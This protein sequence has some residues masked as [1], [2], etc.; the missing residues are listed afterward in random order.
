MV[1]TIH[2]APHTGFYPLYETRRKEVTPLKKIVLVAVNA[3]Y[4]HSNAA[5]YSLIRYNKPMQITPLEFTANDGFHYILSEIYAS[6]P[7][8]LGFSCYIWNIHIILPLVSAVKKI[9]PDVTVILGGPEVSYDA[10]QVLEQTPADIVVL[11]EGE[12]TLRQ[13]LTDKPL[14]MIKGIIYRNENNQIITNPLR[15]KLFVS[16]IPFPYNEEN[17]PQNKII[18]YESSRGCPFSCGYCLS[19]N[20]KPVRFLPLRR[21]FA[22]LDFFI[23]HRVTQVKFTDRT[24]NC[25]KNRA[26]LIWKYLIDN[27]NGYT[28]FHFELAADLLDDEILTEL[29]NAPDG[30]FQFEIGIQS[31][32]AETL[33]AINRNMLPNRVTENIKKIKTHENIH[34][35]LDLIAGLPAESYERFKESFDTVYDLSPD[36]LQLGFLKLLKGSTLRENAIKHGIVYN[37]HPPYEVLSTHDITYGELKNLKQIEK[38]VDLLYNSGNFT[39]TLSYIRPFFPSP[40]YFYES[41][42][43]YWQTQGFHRSSQNLY[44]VY[45]IL[46]AFLEPFCD[47]DILANHLKY[48]WYNN[49]NQKNFPL[50]LCAF[51]EE[52][53]KIINDLYKSTQK[54]KRY[55][56]KKFTHPYHGYI[57]FEYIGKPRPGSQKKYVKTVKFIISP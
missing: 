42:A 2:N 24:F 41:F 47:K 53:P 22:D 7:D 32:H 5:I 44:A 12:E 51:L 37:D 17:L 6:A 20:E 4:I 21:V 49:G 57:L 33:K 29:S 15:E 43:M 50:P 9:I 26:L 38:M 18:Y 48:D 52:D 3:K 31:T 40:F 10:E 13:I 34:I 28:N 56:I 35:H 54:S 55:P 11:G 16:D 30:L 1:G 25:D 14:C 23:K 39:N 36:M 46:A 45:E 19:F 27:D 8:I